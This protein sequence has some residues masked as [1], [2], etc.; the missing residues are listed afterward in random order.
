MAVGS[1]DAGRESLAAALR[2]HRNA[3]GLTQ[4]QV[5]E[6]AGVSV[7]TISD[8]ER[9]IHPTARRSTL[10]RLTRAL[11][12]SP[13]DAARLLRQESAEAAP[14]APALPPSLRPRPGQPPLVGRDAAR[15]RF[16][17]GWARAVG[18]ERLALV[19]SGE[20]GIGKSRLLGELAAEIAGR[21]VTVL[22]GRCDESIRAPYGPLLEALRPR[23]R[24][25]VVAAH[26]A[27]VG[28]DAGHL[29]L[30]LP[31]LA[32]L[33]TPPPPDAD[34][35]TS[36]ARLL[37]ALEA[38]IA[39]LAG[40]DAPVAV[41]VD[42]LQSAD[43]ST[44][45]VLRHVLRSG[46]AE[47]FLLVAS[48]R[49]TDV[50]AD[51]PLPPFFED[52]QR[53]RLLLRTELRGLDIDALGEL[54]ARTTGSRPGPEQLRS[55]QRETGGNPF[56]VEEILTNAGEQGL[57]LDGALAAVPAGARDVVRARVGRLTAGTRDALTVAA[58]VGTAFDP[59][60]VER[61]AGPHA[62]GSVSDAAAS[63]FVQ[64]LDDE[65]SFRHGIVQAALLRDQDPAEV[66][67]VHWSVGTALEE[68]H[69]ADR[70][71][72]LE[73]IAHHLRLGAAAGDPVKASDAL[74]ELG[75]QQ[76][77]AIALEEAVTSLTAALEVVP[78]AEDDGLRRMA[79]LETLAETHFWRDDPDA[80]RGA[81]VAAADLARRFGTPD[82]LGRTAVVAARWNRGGELD[83]TVL[84]L[85]DEAID[86]L[87][88]AESGLLAQLLAMR[89]YV[90]QGAARGFGTRKLAE[91]AELMAR[92]SGDAESLALTLLVQTYTEAGA[93]TIDRTRRIVA[94]LEEVV[95]RVVREDLRQQYGAMALRS[96]ALLQLMGGDRAAYE[97]TR[98]ELGAIAESMRATFIRSQM[99]HW[100]SAILRAEGCFAAADERSAAALANWSARPDAMR[101][102]LVQ[103]ANS[104]L[105]RGEHERVLPQIEQ[106]V[107]GNTSS[108]GYAWRAA[109]A[110]GLAAVG[111][112]ADATARLQE[113][114][115]DKFRGLA[116]DH[117]RPHALRWLAEAIA[118]LHH[119]DLA[120]DLLP[121][122][123]PYA[124][125]V[126]VGSGIT[127]VE[128]AADRVLGQL[129]ACLGDRDGAIE[130]YERADELETRLGFEAL[131]LRTR[132]W[133]AASLATDR[134]KRAQAREL[135]RT[136]ATRADELGM[137][138][139]ARESAAVAGA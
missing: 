75:H 130:R 38:L 117:Q 136:T 63:G 101:V 123:E 45:A 17:D 61:V 51:H 12:L 21:G 68:L 30:V 77:R 32:A 23:L 100:D 37:D 73:A 5:A 66:V 18:G 71:R 11:G 84:G 60:V 33:V 70:E 113:L 114:G 126:L 109:L 29:A 112:R 2:R 90:L 97:V 131:A 64:R 7:R 92:R 56:F 115:A 27:A 127:G 58:V 129:L 102:F 3:S 20:A 49:D 10:E 16:A 74:S 8:L 79:I 19:F 52:L 86:R 132:A 57:T 36:R 87:A 69:G 35:G 91:D 31:E 13:A 15:A 108:I 9:G 28:A 139:L 138:M 48:C 34:P 110:C 118:R 80:M 67:R 93:P 62:A 81:A 88:G 44:L 124:E 22:G 107:A 135:A 121:L 1:S 95:A 26:L 47:G 55:L 78:A 122:A 42:D 98:R 53:D 65:W 50:T 43:P 89:A 24:E 119:G 41:F 137:A 59:R 46:R 25:D 106:A 54:V 128:A 6:R 40:A 125:L 99:L 14:A 72:H 105:E 83:P 39:S 103:S 96:R 104:G 133:A 120:R 134:N 111:R 82:D 94:D 85:L 116:D 4:E 76:F